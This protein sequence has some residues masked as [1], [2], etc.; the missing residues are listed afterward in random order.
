[1]DFA[2]GVR[3]EMQREPCGLLRAPEAARFLG[4]SR[5]T[6]YRLD[7]TGAVPRAVYIGRMRRWRVE[8]LRR[9]VDRDCPSRDRWEEMKP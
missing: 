1:M 2:P 4:M 5:A 3:E 9:W 7:A 6:F 8:E